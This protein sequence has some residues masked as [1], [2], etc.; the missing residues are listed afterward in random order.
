MF[1]SCN[2]WLNIQPE[3]SVDMKELFSR[4]E[5][6]CEALNGIYSS[7]TNN[8]SY[9]GLLTV[10][11]P[12]A[13]MQNYSYEPQDYTT[14][15]K[16]AAFDLNDA[17][18]KRR[19]AS[20]W[21]SA[22][23]AIA[24]CNLI[25]QQID[26]KKELFQAGMYELVKGEALAL[27][28]F[29]HFDML[30]LF[31]PSYK[32]A[33]TKDAIPYVMAYSNK[34]TPLS[35][36]SQVLDYAADDLEKAKTLLARDPIRG[37]NYVVGYNTDGDTITEQQ[38]PNLFLQNRRHRLNYYGVCG[39]LARV[40]LYKEDYPKALSNA[41]EVFNANKFKWANPALVLASAEDKDRVMY[42]ELVFA[43]YNGNNEESLKNRFA[44]SRV[45]YFVSTTHLRAIYEAD[46]VGGGDYRFSGWFAA[47]RLGNDRYQ[48]V[49][50]LRNTA[51]GGDK[52]FLVV[53]SIRLSEM[54]YIAAEAVYASNPAL[55]WEYLNTVRLKRNVVAPNADFEDALLKEYRKETYAEGQAFYAYKRLNRGIVTEAGLIYDPSRTYTLPLPDDEIEFGER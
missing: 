12:E 14:Y 16:T 51:E 24:N 30:R 41:Q 39:T 33:P 26:E 35:S 8:M 45:N 44:D 21:S 23:S 11:L 1:A 36:V 43:W 47:S 55:A 32:A 4:E 20:A 19:L 31:A 42:P 22:Y 37:V 18:F 53:P 38:N 34:V 9:G 2:D 3:S 46:N 49:K 15:V 28:A 27:R 7:A 25:L 52:H 40:Y 29:L 17:T 10:E 50:Y 13:L 5:G 54:Y 48:L 6:F